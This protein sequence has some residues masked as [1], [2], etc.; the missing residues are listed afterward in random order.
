MSDKDVLNHARNVR[1]LAMYMP[2]SVSWSRRGLWMIVLYT[3]TLTHMVAC[4]TSFVFEKQWS[5]VFGIVV[6]N[7]IPLL[8][9]RLFIIAV[10]AVFGCRRWWMDCSRPSTI[11]IVT[12]A[13][14]GFGSSPTV[15]DDVLM[16]MSMGGNRPWQ[17]A[18]WCC[19]VESFVV[20]LVFLLVQTGAKRCCGC[21]YWHWSCCCIHHKAMR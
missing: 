8:L 10:N 20:L 5:R 18:W 11:I 13:F 21:W 3:T 1:S 4:Y 17:L 6:V 12:T 19:G 15:V 14:G 16:L 7:S 2:R 9:I